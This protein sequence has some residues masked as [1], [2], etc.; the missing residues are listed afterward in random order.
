MLKKVLI[1]LCILIVLSTAGVTARL[2]VVPVQ[3]NI[4]GENP[5]RSDE[6]MLAAHRGGRLEFP[7]NTLEAFY[8]AYSVNEDIIMEADVVLT[9][10]EELVLSHDL[11]FDR[12]TSLKEADTEDIEY[13]YLMEEEICFGHENPTNRHGYRKSDGLHPYLND[14]GEEVTPKDVDY[15]EGVEPRHDE[16]FLATTLEELITAFPDN[17]MVLE[18]KPSGETGVRT[19]EKVL[20]LMERLDDE[21]DTF[22]RIL[23]G[24]FRSIVELELMEASQTTHPDLM[25]VPGLISVV[26]FYSL[27]LFRMEGVHESSAH[28]LIMPPD[29]LLLNLS[30]ERIIDIAHEKNHAVIYFAINDAD[31]MRRLLEPGADVIMTGLP[32]E[33]QD[34]L[35]D[36][37]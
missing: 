18:I 24:S 29:F 6:T 22:D 36:Y 27:Q 8:N 14:A 25:Y 12:Q 23:L 2:M 26:R 28:A 10:D 19:T 9:K 16:K 30:T 1:V 35:S 4:E 7:G 33:M 13:S 11:T 31:E 21:Y 20:D 34:V 32:T 15:P 37:D 3:E 17:K 5:F